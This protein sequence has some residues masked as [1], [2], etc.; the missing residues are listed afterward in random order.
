MDLP[1]PA[2]EHGSQP[3]TIQAAIAAAS[4]RNQPAPQINADERGS[5]RNE[6][7]NQP[8]VGRSVVP[9]MEWSRRMAVVTNQSINHS[10]RT[11]ERNHDCASRDADCRALPPSET[12]RIPFRRMGCTVR[13]WGFCEKD[14]IN[15]FGGNPVGGRKEWERTR[16][17][18]SVNQSTLVRLAM[19]R[20]WILEFL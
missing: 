8:S 16:T 9:W 5:R 18:Q 7:R 1:L 4:P 12:T 10:V 2:D 19:T 15:P 17:D 20:V 13:F 14:R 3:H 6:G 11:K